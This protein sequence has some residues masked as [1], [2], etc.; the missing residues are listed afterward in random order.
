MSERTPEDAI[1]H[2][3]ECG[4]SCA[5]DG[6]LVIADL[7]AALSAVCACVAAPNPSDPA[8]LMVKAGSGPDFSAAMVR[9][10]A[11]LERCTPHAR[12]ERVTDTGEQ[13]G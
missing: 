13:R 1:A 4:C 7:R 9:A 2:L 10:L 11:A 5:K 12:P 6:L 8:K 3:T